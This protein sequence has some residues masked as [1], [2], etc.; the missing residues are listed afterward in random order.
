MNEALRDW[1]TNVRRH[2]LRHRLGRRPASVSRD[3]ARLPGGDRP[4]GAR[5]DPERD[6]QLPDALVACVGGGSNAMGLFHAFLDDAG[7]LFGV[8]AAGDGIDTAG[9]PRR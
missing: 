7:A 5:A 6:G 4:R 1:V 2:L 9:T 3:R 8:E